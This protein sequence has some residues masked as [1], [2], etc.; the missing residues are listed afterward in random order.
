M[1]AWGNGLSRS[2]F[3]TDMNE[4]KVEIKN[5]N[6]VSRSFRERSKSVL[7]A[8]DR[9]ISKVALM[10]ERQG[11]L[12]SPVKT[13]RMR[14]S[15]YPVVMSNLVTNVGPKVDYAKY[16]HARVPFMTAARNDVDPK[17]RDIV[18]DEIR[19]ALKMK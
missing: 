18:E 11:K 1:A 9:I 16:V 7:P 5:Y 10:V 4:I 13:G 12:Y 15:I 17:V 2:I 8:L 3:D 14:A 6:E 19:R